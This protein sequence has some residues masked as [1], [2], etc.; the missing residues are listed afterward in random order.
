VAFGVSAETQ[1]WTKFDVPS[2]PSDATIVRMTLHYY[3]NSVE[4]S[5]TK[6]NIVR[7]NFD[8]VYNDAQ[9][10][11]TGMNSGSVSEYQ[12]VNT[13]GWKEVQFWDAAFSDFKLSPRFGWYA[14][15]FYGC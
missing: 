1:G 3:V 7:M 6:F 4:N 9:G 5:Y 15:K 13:T 11:M 2:F 10:I 14:L 12:L 8:P